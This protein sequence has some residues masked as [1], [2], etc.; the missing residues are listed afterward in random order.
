MFSVRSSQHRKELTGS[1]H[2]QDL[3]PAPPVLSTSIILILV[4]SCPSLQCIEIVDN[5]V[6]RLHG[7]AVP[8]VT[9]I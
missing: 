5:V 3:Q 2:H 6:L 8:V 7:S 4:I 1:G 9:I